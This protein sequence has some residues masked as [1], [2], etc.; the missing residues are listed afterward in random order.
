MRIPLKVLEDKNKILRGVKLR[1]Y[2]TKEDEDYIATM[3]HTKELVYNWTLDKLWKNY[4]S[5]KDNMDDYKI[6]PYATLTSMFTKYRNSDD[7]STLVKSLHTGVARVAIKDAMTSFIM[8]RKEIERGGKKPRYHGKKVNSRSFG[9][10]NGRSYILDGKLYT[11]N[12]GKLPR[13]CIELL[14]R[15]YDGCGGNGGL[16]DSRLITY[17]YRPRIVKETD[18][19]YIT[20]SIPRDRNTTLEDKPW[21]EP[22]GIDLG[23][24][25][26][27]QLSTEEFF[28][29]PDVSRLRTKVNDRNREITRLYK[30]RKKRAHDQGLHVWELP[31]SKTELEL[32]DRRNKALKDIHNKLVYFYYS[33]VNDIVKRRPEAIVLETIYVRDIL[34]RTAA[35]G[36]R[37]EIHEVY[38]CMIRYMFES[39]CEEYSI[40]LYETMNNYPSS[41]LCNKCGYKHEKLGGN[42]VFVCPNC[43]YTVD[44][45]LNA[46]LNL[47]DVYVNR[48]VD[49]IKWWNG[50]GNKLVLMDKITNR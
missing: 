28:N 45:D 42:R 22:I 1:L 39:K 3:F 50:Y 15:K 17:W 31:K 47:R 40:P 33:V 41:L 29:Q 27:F 8:L 18:G 24:K 10:R 44:R 35:Y 13:L 43:G 30:L 21:T 26:T 32:I 4:N 38:F 16:K 11:E 48:E 34:R 36:I 46:S 9:L 20:F 14:T 37:K 25:T 49:N 2:T 19:Y 7:C 5:Y 23:C 6:I 12:M